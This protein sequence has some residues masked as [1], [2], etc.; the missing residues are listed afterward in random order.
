[1][2][3]WK[4][5]KIRDI[6]NYVALLY[7]IIDLPKG[8]GIIYQEWKK[9]HDKSTAF[10]TTSKD[11]FYGLKNHEKVSFYDIASYIFSLI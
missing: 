6:P 1:M 11:T 3:A 4:L 10:Y 2:R 5:P 7:T 9:T 8:L